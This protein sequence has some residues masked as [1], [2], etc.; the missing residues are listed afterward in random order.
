MTVSAFL[1]PL[2]VVSLL[3]GGAFFN[4]NKDFNIRNR[5]LGEWT[6]T[7]SDDLVLIKRVGIASYRRSSSE[8]SGSSSP[9]L[10]SFEHPTLRRRKLRL[11]GCQKIV[12]SPNTVVFK[13]RFLSRVLQKYPFLVEAW[14]WALLYWVSSSVP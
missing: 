7:K 3:F 1:E 5:G 6:R 10:T 11:F 8:T 2:V 13:D 12:T 9:T 4:R 14:Y